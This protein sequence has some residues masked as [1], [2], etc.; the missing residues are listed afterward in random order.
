MTDFDDEITWTEKRHRAA[1][2]FA[3]GLDAVRAMFADDPP[4]GMEW[5]IGMQSEDVGGDWLCM[6]ATTGGY[7]VGD[8]AADYADGSEDGEV[9]VFKLGF[10]PAGCIGRM[11][12]FGGW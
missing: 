4:E 2:P 9:Y 8:L 11:R 3:K 12:D 7:D 6:G 1:Y 5:V 10:G